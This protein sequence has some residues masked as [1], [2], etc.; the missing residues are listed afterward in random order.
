[1]AAE[2]RES[3]NNTADLKQ[4][5]KRQAALVE[6]R[7]RV[8]TQ[9]GTGLFS[10]EDVKHEVSRI[11]AEIEVLERERAEKR[12]VVEMAERVTVELDWAGRLLG[13]LRDQL[14]D[15]KLSAEKKRMFI[16]A[17]VSSITILPNGE[18]K[19]VFRFDSHFQR[20]RQYTRRSKAV[21]AVN[22]GRYGCPCR[23]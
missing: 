2:S 15:G 14:L 11:D 16:Q 7:R 5:E 3:R 20:M 21:R 4:L 6:A 9:Y 22:D 19:A 17:L 23:H 10:D 1:L 8:L 12:N 18:A 13:E